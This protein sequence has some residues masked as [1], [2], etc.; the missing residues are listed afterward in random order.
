MAILIIEKGTIEELI[1]LVTNCY[2]DFI[3]HNSIYKIYE[4][5]SA[6]F[7]PFQQINQLVNSKKNAMSLWYWWKF[8]QAFLDK[9]MQYSCACFHNPNISLEQ[10]QKIKNNI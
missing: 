7:M 5:L 9:D 4:Y 8:I 3:S 1:D 2:D 10:A 6:I